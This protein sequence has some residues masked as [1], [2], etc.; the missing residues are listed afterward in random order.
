MATLV[1]QDGHAHL[2]RMQLQPGV[3]SIG[4]RDTNSLVVPDASVSGQHC[5]IEVRE[6]AIHLRDLGSTNGT[7]LEGQPVRE[8]A[9]TDGQKL[10][11]GDVQFMVEAPELPPA[12]PAS[13]R[14]TLGR[15]TAAV[16]EPP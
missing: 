11:L 16:A 15:S 3:N 5:E 4:R 10:T 13:L 1:P 7:F 2:E 9:L 14:V 8:A 6:G 12:R